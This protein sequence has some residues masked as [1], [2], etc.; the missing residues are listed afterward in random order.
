MRS[1]LAHSGR[2]DGCEWGND[3]CEWGN[4]GCE[5]GN[6]GCEWGNDGCEWGNDDKEVTKKPPMQKNMVRLYMKFERYFV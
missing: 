1:C 6:D 4:D 2:N 5:W 3:G